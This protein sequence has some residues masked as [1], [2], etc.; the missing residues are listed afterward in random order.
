MSGFK[1]S[2]PGLRF[3]EEKITP[4]EIDRYETYYIINPSYSGAWVGAAGTAGTSSAIALTK[5][6]VILDYPRNLEMAITGSATGMAG[7]MVVNGHDQFGNVITES[8]GFGS[9]DNGGT[10]VGTK[11]FAEVTSGTLTY[12]TAVGSG[13]SRLGVG[14]S[15][16]TAL[17]GLPTKL[18]GTT[19][20]KLITFTAGAGAATVNG[21][22]IAAFV[23]VPMHAI[24]SPKDLPGTTSIMVWFKSS[25]N[26]ENEAIVSN[27]A[28]RV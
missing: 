13:T 23:D 19:D 16:T 12:G 25:Y 7:T 10:V 2:Q 8:F 27:L 11:V 15:G 22:T 5:T 3:A 14:T 24:K 20:V 6:N 4:D 1:R 9:A 18:G 26:A 21:G 28:Q 17:F